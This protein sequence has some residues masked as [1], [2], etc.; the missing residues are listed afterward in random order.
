MTAPTPEEGF[1]EFAGGALSFKSSSSSSVSKLS[2]EGA[3][4]AL[5]FD[6]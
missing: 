1:E 6:E 4:N 2:L 5:H 3:V